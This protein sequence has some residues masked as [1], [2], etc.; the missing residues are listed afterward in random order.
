MCFIVSKGK[1]SRSK[2]ATK[3]I[4]CYKKSSQ[5]W[6]EKK[7]N[8]N[9]PYYSSFQYYVNKRTPKVRLIKFSGEIN[10]GYHSYNNVEWVRCSNSRVGK[11][12][13]P[14]GTRYFKNPY[15]YVSETLIFKGWLTKTEIKRLCK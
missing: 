2:I 9:P 7:S 8:F 12:I 10:E 13:I 1:N 14:K 6:G 4:V 15:E 11:F 3:N 5:Y